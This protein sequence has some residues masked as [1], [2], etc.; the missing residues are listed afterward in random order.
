MVARLVV[1]LAIALGSSLAAPPPA[2][3]AES[4]E[5]C[6]QRVIR[7][8][9][10]GGRVDGVY[11]LRCYRAAIRALPNDVLHYSVA[12]RDIA[13]AL[14]Y[15]RRGR[16]DPGS[17]PKVAPTSG[18]GTPAPK[19]AVPASSGSEPRTTPDRDAAER[20]P[21]GPMRLAS[22]QQPA[23]VSSAVP[24]PVIALAAL[25]GVLLLSGAAGWLAARR[26]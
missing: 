9:Y 13:R 20:P 5:A 7:D 12:D 6:A 24:Y 17:A 11:P 14:A 1:L 2:A 10:S 4:L 19:P 23:A 15:A 8:W 3:A 22:G 21:S 26:R 25:A 16:R 18:G